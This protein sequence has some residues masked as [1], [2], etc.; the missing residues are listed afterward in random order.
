MKSGFKTTE[1]WLSI[2]GIL[3]NGYIQLKT[4]NPATM[5]LAISTGMASAGYALSRGMAKKKPNT[6]PQ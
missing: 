1:F 6:L 2:L 3:A 4:Q 5:G